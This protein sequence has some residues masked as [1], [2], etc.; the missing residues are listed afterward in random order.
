MQEYM[1]LFRKRK[2]ID[3]MNTILLSF[4]DCWFSQLESGNTKFE[5]RMVLPKD[6]TRVFFYVSRP[7]MA[8]TGIAHFGAR[9][10]LKE[11]LLTYGSRSDALKKRIEEYLVDCRYAVKVFDFQKTS[12]ICLKQIRSIFPGFVVPRMY[13]YITDEAIL[14][15]FETNLIPIGRKQE[16]SFSI[17][18]DDDI[19]V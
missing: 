19:C 12:R 1:V 11:W 4:Q 5:Y 8:V 3:F 10:E 6:E 13:Y 14:N 7:V 17:V 18:Y 9:E 15:Y 16:N 2:V